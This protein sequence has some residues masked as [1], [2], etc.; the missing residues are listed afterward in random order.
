M[1]AL[2]VVVVFVSA[3]FLDFASVRY[4]QAVDRCLR[5]RAALWGVAMYGVS[6]IGFLSVVD[7]SWWLMIP[8]CLGFWV[9]TMLAI[10]ATPRRH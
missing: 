5:H 3:A 8:E 4:Q 10:P 1:M 2:L 9:G 6:T 7:V